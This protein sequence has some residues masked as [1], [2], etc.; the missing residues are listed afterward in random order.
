MPIVA[1][2]TRASASRFY[3]Q[4]SPLNPGNAGGNAYTLRKADGTALGTYRSVAEAQAVFNRYHGPS[5]VYRWER[6]DLAGDIE[7]HVCIGT[8]LDPGEIWLLQPGSPLQ[9]NSPDSSALDQWMEP[10]LNINT[11]KLASVSTNVINTVSDISG[12]GNY[13]QAQSG[14]PYLVESDP[15]FLGRPVID[16]DFAG[17]Q[18]GFS[19]PN[20]GS[21]TRPYTVIVVA[22]SLNGF[23]INGHV[24]ITS[25]NP[26]IRFF[27]GFDG[28]THVW[29]MRIGG[30]PTGTQ[31]DVSAETPAPAILVAKVEVDK[32]SFRCN[33]KD[34]GT[35]PA[36]TGPVPGVVI[37]GGY[38]TDPFNG[39][40]AFHALSRIADPDNTRIRQTERYLSEKF[41]IPLG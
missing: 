31:S 29:E 33:G 30:F 3:S 15:N 9:P 24:W 32:T 6:R 27:V 10:D 37:L 7:Q 21:I 12:S 41:G 38:D 26:R 40:I 16:F 17:T 14:D 35:V 23:N 5:R 36:A 19:V 13:L 8:P 39:R 11:V 18:A 28:A 22:N 25:N 34:F 2:V 4:Q 1:A 20:L